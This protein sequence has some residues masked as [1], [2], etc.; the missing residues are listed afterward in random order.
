MSFKEMTI[1]RRIGLGFGGVLLLLIFLGVSSYLGVGNVVDNGAEVIEGNRLDGILAQK[2]VDHL[3]WASKVNTLLTDDTVSEL[4]VQ[5]DW[6][7]CGL[8]QWYYGEERRQAEERMPSLAPLFAK[9][10]EPHKGLHQSAAGIQEVYRQP[11]PGLE[12][13][14]SERFTDHALWA[15]KVTQSLSEEAVGLPL[16]R[17]RTK[18]AVDQAYS[19]LES[20]DSDFHL[21]MDLDKQIL[22]KRL[23][24]DEQ[25]NI[26]DE[27]FYFVLDQDGQIQ[28]HSDTK[29]LGKNASGLDSS[30]GT[31]I[32]QTAINTA[33][34]DGEGLL[35]RP[36]PEPAAGLPK[37]AVVYV[38]FYQ[39]WGW[40]IGTG[41]YPDVQNEA[42]MVRLK[43]FS[44]GRPFTLGVQLDPTK[45]AFG[46]YMESS[47]TAALMKSFPAFGE[48]MAAI[49]DPHRRLHQAAAAIEKAVNDFDM[50]LAV[51][52]FDQDVKPA[53][54]EVKTEFDK[55]IAAEESLQEGYEKAKAIYTKET[56]AHLKAVQALLG[57]L[58]R[59]A[60]KNI[61]SD[62]VMLSS[63]QSTK[64]NVVIIGVAAL[65]LGILIAWLISRS[66]VR[67]LARVAEGIGTGSDQVATVAD[68]VSKSS[69]SLAEG[70]SEQAAAL[71]E[72][73]SSMEEMA[74][75]TRR[76]ADSA[77]HADTL[78]S[79][80]RAVVGQAG[81]SMT[82]MTQAMK[83]ISAS[84]EE[85]GKIIK[86]ID[87]I[88]F[89][90][91][92]LA[93]NAA[94]EAARA[95]EAGQGFAVVADEVRNLA[96]RAGEA[97]KN[98]E[99][100][101]ATTITKIGQ[102][103]NLVQE[104]AE[105]F[106][107]VSEKADKVAELV[108]EIAAASQE[109]AQGIDQVNQALSQLD[110]VTQGNA[111]TAEESSAASEEMNAQ[112]SHMRDL[113]NELLVL[114]GGADTDF[115]PP[116][117][118]KKR[119]SAP[120]LKPALRKPV[121][122]PAAVPPKAAGRRRELNPDEI[123]PMDDEFKDF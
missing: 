83:D 50:A 71:E 69:Q 53:L 65:L 102:G 85:I 36:R 106:S 103:N 84:G 112:A 13:I 98:T 9:I 113:V 12:L 100:L 29:L 117:A 58:R 51:R 81:K 25:K 46:K 70:S 75:M 43:D 89:Q 14:L 48:A 2:E 79:Q 118:A 94:V 107:E 92:L 80:T 38:R 24:E 7:K 32:L 55:A 108:G 22:A 86:T 56:M 44:E 57:E 40:I 97:A 66:L 34:K 6:H 45:C 8:G 41:I 121:S 18:A 99:T 20:L 27:G 54:A 88:A 96:Q 37:P 21:S 33:V 63:A 28:A 3:V 5:L 62:E 52:I 101:I 76:N 61:M 26:G 87:E 82:G 4:D 31:N 78:V 39:P 19:I 1:G 15:S 105:A 116:P 123:I 90:T 114:V 115:N 73:S 119:I 47:E 59:E 109:Q 67:N 30:S 77:S 68:E 64:R 111:A 104:A 17:M 110:Q 60:K 95:G 122:P 72:T 49:V 11:H 74:S 42:L 93:L 23:L 10:E 35:V 91:N 16:L 120:A